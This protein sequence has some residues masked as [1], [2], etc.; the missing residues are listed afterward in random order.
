MGHRPTKNPKPQDKL[1][2]TLWLRMS[3]KLMAES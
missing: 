3:S 2:Y 1:F